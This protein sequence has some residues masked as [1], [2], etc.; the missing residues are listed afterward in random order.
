MAVIKS[1]LR[2]DN[3]LGPHALR[4]TGNIDNQA[5]G[6]GKQTG[7]GILEQVIS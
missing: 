5:G 7:A 2:P 4:R 6:F 1:R 3:T